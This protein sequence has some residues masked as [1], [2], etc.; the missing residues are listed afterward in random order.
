MRGLELP[1]GTDVQGQPVDS[2]WRSP[3]RCPKKSQRLRTKLGAASR[4]RASAAYEHL[5]TRRHHRA[6][7]QC[8]AAA[9][10]HAHRRIHALEAQQPVFEVAGQALDRRA[11]DERVHH[12]RPEPVQPLVNLCFRRPFVDQLRKIAN[13]TERRGR[14]IKRPDRRQRGRD[15]FHIVD[16]DEIAELAFVGTR[17]RPASSVPAHPNTATA[18]AA[19]LSR[20]HAS[21]RDP[22]SEK[23]RCDPIHPV[24][25]C[26]ESALRPCKQALCILAADI[27]VF[28]HKR[29]Q[30]EKREKA[31]HIRQSGNEHG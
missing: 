7:F 19:P 16:A 10:A 3:A 11:G 31:K 15:R 9:R 5:F 22:A 13:V 2:F 4:R 26:A 1:A 14:R 28:E 18:A 25:R 30:T 8:L 20:H 12:R 24:C 21:C 27:E 29:R 17:P 23:R 6:G